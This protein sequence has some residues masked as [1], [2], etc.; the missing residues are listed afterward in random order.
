M[1]HMN[2]KRQTSSCLYV[3]LL[4]DRLLAQ[5]KNFEVF[6]FFFYVLPVA[7]ANAKIDAC[8]VSVPVVS[9]KRCKPTACSVLAKLI[10]GMGRFELPAPRPPDGYSNLAELHPEVG[11][12][13][14]RSVSVFREAKLILFLNLRRI[15]NGV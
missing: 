13:V 3:N 1:G 8:P 11:V 15:S 5:S 12:G 10:V 4:D 14:L 9:L 2:S 7:V 6:A